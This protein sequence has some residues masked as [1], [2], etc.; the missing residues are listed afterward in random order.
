MSLTKKLLALAKFEY[1]KYP[2]GADVATQEH[3]DTLNSGGATEAARLLPLIEALVLV[4]QAAAMSDTRY[5]DRDTNGEEVQGCYLE[6]ALAKLE[7]LVE[8]IP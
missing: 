4:A 2:L 8:V 5:R 6:D 1:R 3:F 7:S